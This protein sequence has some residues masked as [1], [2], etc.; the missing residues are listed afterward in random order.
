LESYA[1]SSGVLDNKPYCLAGYEG[2]DMNSPED[3]IG[4]KCMNLED[5]QIKT[6]FNLSELPELEGADGFLFHR[7]V[8]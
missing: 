1:E 2:K 4:F 3:V 7:K 8:K 6:V 5:G